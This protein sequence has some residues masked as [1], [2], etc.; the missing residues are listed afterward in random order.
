MIYVAYYS[1]FSDV[2]VFEQEI[3]C[4]RV[5]V[6]KHMEVAMLQSGSSLKDFIRR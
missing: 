4:L 3:D 6:E 2:I 1:D 5:A